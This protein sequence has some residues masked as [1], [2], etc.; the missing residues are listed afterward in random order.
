MIPEHNA[1][2]G[3]NDTLN[4]LRISTLEVV[5]VLIGGGAWCL[6]LIS[7]LVIGY[8][9][10][11]ALVL[12]AILE[13]VCVLSYALRKEHF[14]WAARMLILGLW[15]SNV[16]ATR[17]FGLTIVPYLFSLIILVASVL[18]KRQEAI[19]LALVT[20]GFLLNTSIDQVDANGVLFPILFLWFSLLTSLAAHRSF[21][22]ALDIAWLQQ[23]Y[24]IRQ[25]HEA[26]E[27][28][29]ELM[30]LTKDLKRTEEQLERAN[31][32]VHHAWLAAE[33]ARRKKAQFA[34]TVS[35]ELRTP[36]NLIVGFSDS[37][38]QIA[39]VVWCPAALWLLVGYEHD[40]PECAAF[41]GIDQRCSGC[42][43]D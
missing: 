25:M 5:L 6:M 29:Q 28:R 14:G 35:H 42:F 10:V 17:Q 30:R 41:A 9:S 36:I 8:P 23:D 4:E 24:A 16:V 26:R 27:H 2:P 38:C 12:F 43:P 3:R 22:Q 15:V 33:D 7:Y 11:T 18:I 13:L 21:Y 1:D 34:A 32:Q 20:M 37:D 19:L 39:P 40:L 31:S